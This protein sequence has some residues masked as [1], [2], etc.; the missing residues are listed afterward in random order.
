MKLELLSLFRIAEDKI[1]VIPHGIN[2]R[3]CRSRLS[4]SDARQKLDIDATAHVILFFGQ[5]DT[6]KGVETLI[7]AVSSLVKSDPSILL[8][9]AGQAKRKSSYVADLKKQ[10]G[11][12]L[13]D[14]NIKFDLRYIPIEEVESYFISAD[15]LVLPYKRILQSGVIFLAYRFGL[16][17]IATDV[18]S[19]SE[20]I[21]DGKTGYIC[22]P[23]NPKDLAEKISNFFSSYLFIKRDQTR[24]HIIEFAEKKYSWKDI[25]KKTFNLYSEVLKKE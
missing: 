3:V 22:A 16:P 7:E 19:F 15:C 18:G 2:N 11:R 1:I 13:P 6:Y 4:F 9:I 14:K 23:D 24:N 8:I 21:I 17:I 20:D 10:A 5:I 25:S 12:M